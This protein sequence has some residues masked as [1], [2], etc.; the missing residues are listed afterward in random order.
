MKKVYKIDSQLEAQA[1]GVDAQAKEL[2]AQATQLHSMKVR[3][4]ELLAIIQSLKTQLG[5]VSVRESSKN[6][7]TH[8]Q[9]V[10]ALAQLNAVVA[11]EAS[12]Q[13]A[14]A[15]A[16]Q[17]E[18]TAVQ[19]SQEAAFPAKGF[20]LHAALHAKETVLKAAEEAAGSEAISNS[21]VGSVQKP[22]PQG[23]VTPGSLSLV[24]LHTHQ[25]VP[26]AGMQGPMED[27]RT[28]L[29]AQTLTRAEFRPTRQQDLSAA[30]LAETKAVPVPI[31]PVMSP[32]TQSLRS[33]ALNHQRG[34]K[35]Y[36]NKFSAGVMGHFRES[37]SAIRNS[38]KPYKLPLL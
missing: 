1:S 2:D 23:C 3:E 18:K 30:A 12:L 33:S 6:E 10:V 24:T 19:V 11:R 9:T 27:S 21:Q 13:N 32:A 36:G 5:A 4:V 17:A 8:L 28:G 25:S 16:L 35:L 29:D 15:N 20:T 34:I 14:L 31:M 26:Q 7:G 37:R 38:Y 22:Q